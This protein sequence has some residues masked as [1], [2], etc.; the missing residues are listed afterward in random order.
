MLAEYFREKDGAET[1]ETDGGFLAWIKLEHQFFISDF[2][3]KSS[4]RKS[5]KHFL[6]LMRLAYRNAE[7]N[8]CTEFS[9]Y[10]HKAMK[11]F[12]EVLFLRLKFGFRIVLMNAEKVGMVLPLKDCKWVAEE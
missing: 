5:G 8:N 6:E 3:I 2:H 12:D 11:N 7:A 1:I 4:H 10:L 9:C